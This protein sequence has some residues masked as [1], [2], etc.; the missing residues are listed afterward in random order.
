MAAGARAVESGRGMGTLKGLR[1]TYAVKALRN[2][3]RLKVIEL[4][5]AWTDSEWLAKNAPLNKRERKVGRGKNGESRARGVVDKRQLEAWRCDRNIAF[6]GRVRLQV[7]IRRESKNGCCWTRARELKLKRADVHV[8][9]GFTRETALVVFQR[10][11][12]LTQRII[13]RVQRRT[14]VQQSHGERRAAIVRQRAEERVQGSA[15]RTGQVAVDAVGE[16]GA[17]VRL[18]DEVVT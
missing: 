13:A 9:T 16:P 15:G 11:G 3:V 2:I 5:Q 12:R 18:T 4:K 6:E 8:G 17:A 7:A 1:R 14:A 10:I